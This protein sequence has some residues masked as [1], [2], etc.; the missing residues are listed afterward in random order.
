MG[1][2][3]TELERTSVGC[4]ITPPLPPPMLGLAP[5]RRYV[6]RD[7]G[8]PGGQELERHGPR[9]VDHEWRR[10]LRAVP[11][12]GGR[13]HRH[14]SA[15]AAAANHRHRRLRRHRRLHRRR[16]STH[17]LPPPAI[18]PTPPPPG[19]R[20]RGVLQQRRPLFRSAMR[21]HAR[22]GV[23]VCWCVG[24]LVGVLVC[25]LVGWLVGW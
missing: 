20:Y 8:V 23:L 11:Y 3:L 5:G 9:G 17:A 18:N 6:R 1:P 4:C 19:M 13:G 25:W 12:D 15:G 2:Q 16:P 24:V 10:F 14:T 22:E 21:V 7:Q